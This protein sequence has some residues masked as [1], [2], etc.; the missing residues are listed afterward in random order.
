[1]NIPL[2][3]IL[4][5]GF[6]LA[7]CFTALAIVLFVKRASNPGNNRAAALAWFSTMEAQAD[8]QRYLGS[9]STVVSDWGLS[10]LGFANYELVI[11]CRTKS[12]RRYF[13]RIVTTRC[14]VTDWEI[15]AATAEDFGEVD[16]AQAPTAAPAAAATPVNPAPST[17]ESRSE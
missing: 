17:Q 3:D 2:N 8:G 12:G 7:C 11:A 1:M 9:R 4:R 14:L 13:L 5:I 6:F 10:R 15:V 16:P